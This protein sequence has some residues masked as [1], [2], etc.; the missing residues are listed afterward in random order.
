MWWLI[1]LSNMW[2]MA[3]APVTSSSQYAIAQLVSQA[4]TA[5]ILVLR[6]ISD[7]V[8]YTL[9]PAADFSLTVRRFEGSEWVLD[10]LLIRDLEMSRTY[11]LEVKG[12]QG[13]VRDRR[14]F[15]SW[16]A[17]A[18]QGARVAFASCMHDGFRNQ[19]AIWESLERVR[20]DLL[21]LNGDT[22]YADVGSDGTP[23]G[24]WNRY[25]ETRNRLHLFRWKELVPIVANWDDHDYGLN[26]AFGDFEHKAE[27]QT[28]FSA[29]FHPAPTSAWEAGRGVGSRL[30]GYGLQFLM[31]DGRSFRSREDAP[32]GA[33]WGIEQEDWALG[34]LSGVPTFLLNGS[35]I[36][37]GYRRKDAVEF[38]HPMSLRTFSEHL[39]L[40][41]SPVVLVS[42]DV[43]FSEVMDLEPG[44]LG[45]PTVEITSSSMHSY[46]VPW[47]QYLT[48]NPRRRVS[49]WRH[50]FVLVESS[51]Q[52]EA[53]HLRVSSVGTSE[54]VLFQTHV[55]LPLSPQKK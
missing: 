21:I 27:T 12:D 33:H 42:G 24:L 40:A 16:D 3:G 14:R 47:H 46:T 22:V 18:L 37:G 26:N 38:Q 49:T 53:W 2:A 7:D 44:L 15:R 8:H 25:V 50:N 39:S 13:L 29:F 1:L 5:Q 6:G 45:Y 17:S 41:R 55:S 10:H 54:R 48:Y 4:G 36:F 20:P 19:D 28:I 32:R 35:Q 9:S 34:H 23:L 11:Q 30:L 43:H 51:L 52:P 31:M